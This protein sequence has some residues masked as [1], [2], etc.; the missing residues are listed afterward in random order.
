MY[1]RNL[2]CFT[3]ATYMWCDINLMQTHV[4]TKAFG[5]RYTA[6]KGGHVIHLDIIQFKVNKKKPVSPIVMIAGLSVGK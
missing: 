5:P 2:F 1:F 6:N 4:A 3:P